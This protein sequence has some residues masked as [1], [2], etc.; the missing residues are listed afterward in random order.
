MILLSLPG[1]TLPG[2]GRL[3]A[4]SIVTS[5][6]SADA[7]YP[8]MTIQRKVKDHAHMAKSPMISWNDCVCHFLL[9]H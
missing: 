3:R 8:E 9:S 1:A 5:A 2:G 6:P 7:L 4:I